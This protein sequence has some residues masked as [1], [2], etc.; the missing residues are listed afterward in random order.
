M[1][2]EGEVVLLMSSGDWRPTGLTVV[3]GAVYVLEHGSRN[4][5][6]V[7]KIASDGS[8]TTVGSADRV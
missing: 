8:I 5:P 3:D 4:A 2:P 7:R 1:T 6:R